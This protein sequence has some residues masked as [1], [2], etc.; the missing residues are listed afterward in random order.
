MSSGTCAGVVMRSS[1]TLESGVLVYRTPYSPELVA[2]LKSAV[3]PTDRR[4]DPNA[5]VWLVTPSHL[6][7]LKQI[8]A[9]YLGEQVHCQLPLDH[10]APALE[11]RAVEVRYIGATKDRGSDERTAYGWCAGEWS[12]VFPESVLRE[13][14]C[15]EQRLNEAP[16]LYAVLGIK[17][18]ATE[19]VVKSAFRRLARVT[20][21]DVNK[22]PTAAEDFRALK[23]AYDLLSDAAKRAKYDAGLALSQSIHTETGNRIQGYRPPL[24]CGLILAEGTEQLGRFVVSKILAWADIQDSEG[25]VLSTSWPA[26]ADIFTEAWV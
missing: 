23:A 12:V 9:Q 6:G 7:T 16:T 26:G 14:F 8:T 22:E 13:W 20:H 5:K 2:A 24:R 11:T 10:Q 4:W 1:L 3:P 15:A 17:R 18:D 19:D 25:R 21:P